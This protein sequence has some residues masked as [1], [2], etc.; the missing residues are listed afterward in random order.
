MDLEGFSKK[1]IELYQLSEGEAP[2]RH[3]QN[4]DL[5][6]CNFPLPYI[7]N[8]YLFVRGPFRRFP[9]GYFLGRDNFQLSNPFHARTVVKQ[10]HECVT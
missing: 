7:L 5:D 4:I 3:Y 1:I 6:N 9:D 2:D 10:D 8:H